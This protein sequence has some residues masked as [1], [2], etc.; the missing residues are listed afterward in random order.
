MN[1]RISQNDFRF[2]ITPQDLDTLLHGRDID[3][4][5]CIGTHCFGY[6]ISPVTQDKKMKLEMAVS[7]F[8]LF[9]PRETLEE[10]QDLGRSKDGISIQQGDVTLSLQLD[11]KTQVKKAA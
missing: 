10:L 5:V 11:I 7:G 3:Q 4:R 8:C 2:R 9:V 1:L 6:G